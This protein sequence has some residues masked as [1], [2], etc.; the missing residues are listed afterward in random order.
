M[1]KLQPLSTVGVLRFVWGSSGGLKA[2]LRSFD[3]YLALVVWLLATPM[4]ISAKWQDQVISVLPNLLGF[5]LGGFAIFLGFGS[6]DFKR[7]IARSDES[8]SPYLSVSAAFMLFISVQLAAL[9]SAIVSSALW[10]RACN[11]A[12]ARMSID[13]AG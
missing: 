11:I 6:D 7:A 10:S 13:I 9:M 8:S 5:T 2:M 3:F 4:W 12:V 1:T